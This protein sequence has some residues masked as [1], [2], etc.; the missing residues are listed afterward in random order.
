[1]FL[2]ENETKIRKILQHFVSGTIPEYI[3]EMAQE[4]VPEESIIKTTVDAND[5]SWEVTALVQGEDFQN[6]SPKISI[7]LTEE[8]IKADCNCQEFFTDA[9]KHVAALASKFLANFNLET[10]QEVTANKQHNWRQTFRQ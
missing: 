8:T 5:S 10:A 6:Y 1:M 3:L 7:D 4:A 2:E 9:C